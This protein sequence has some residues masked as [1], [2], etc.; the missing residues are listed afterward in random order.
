MNS[1][2]VINWNESLQFSEVITVPL[3]TAGKK[4]SVKVTAS[5]SE[6]TTL[7]FIP[8]L[9]WLLVY[10]QWESFF[11]RRR[12]FFFFPGMYQTRLWRV[13]YFCCH[14]AFLFTVYRSWDL[15]RRTLFRKITALKSLFFESSMMY[16][17]SWQTFCQWRLKEEEGLK[18][19]ELTV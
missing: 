13:L 14:N 12:R 4:V 11:S 16:I 7:I 3:N 5:L 15:E 19:A 18:T 2:V 9:V 6:V 8:S 1:Y 17:Y 10:R